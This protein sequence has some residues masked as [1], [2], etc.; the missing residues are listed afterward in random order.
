M[1]KPPKPASMSLNLAPMVDVMMCLIIFFLLASALIDQEN[2]KDLLL[3]W[4]AA[5]EEVKKSELGRRVTVNVVHEDGAEPRYVTAEWDGEQI[6]QTERT[7]EAIER[8]LLERAERAREVGEELR[9]II[10]ADAEA[11]YADVEAVLRA[12]GQAQI[13][14]IV[15]SANHGVGPEGGS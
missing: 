13:A 15:F 4:A 6:R 3:P 8:L 7:P 14:K 2:Y 11:T 9:C 5:A 10:R 1:F 12:A